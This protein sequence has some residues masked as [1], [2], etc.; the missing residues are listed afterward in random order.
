MVNSGNSPKGH[1]ILS[2]EHSSKL[3]CLLEE[4]FA[5][6]SAS[7]GRLAMDFWAINSIKKSR[8]FFGEAMTKKGVQKLRIMSFLNT[9]GF[10]RTK[11]LCGMNAKM[12]SPTKIFNI[13]TGV[14]GRQNVGFTS[15]FLV[16]NYSYWF[17][18]GLLQ[19]QKHLDPEILELVF[20]KFLVI[21]TSKNVH[22][23]MHRSQASENWLS[24]ASLVGYL[25]FSH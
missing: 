22:S 23:Y 11:D 5:S 6:W 4:I 18:L 14:W 12:I 3:N 13:I 20:V 15:A 10:L 17:P 7:P 9:L 8:P 2:R 21:K 25:T 19:G 24:W 1:G 16:M